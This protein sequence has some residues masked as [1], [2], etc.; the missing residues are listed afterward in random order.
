MK[1]YHPF[2]WLS[3]SLQKNVFVIMFPVTLIVMY[4]MGILGNPLKTTVAPGGI[5]DYELAGTLAASQAILKSW[6]EAERIYVG[7]GLGFDFVYIICYSI[8]IA[9]GC[10]LIARALSL[11]IPILS[12]IGFGLAWTLF[13]AGIL[14]GIENYSLIQLL[15]GAQ[16]E[17]FAL[18]A[19]WCAIPKFAFVA[20][21][22]V[23]VVMGTVLAFV[24]KPRQ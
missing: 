6:G 7:L 20:L 16:A 21:G 19:R 12:S 18:I 8:T 5:V 11:R 13:I 4:V 3:E 10:V 17:S 22:L 15:L 23:Y 24:T 14:D 9:L 2:A 1:L